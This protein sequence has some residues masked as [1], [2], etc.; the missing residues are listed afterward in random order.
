MK[1]IICIGIALLLILS[2]CA[3]P[4]STPLPT[5]SFTQGIYEFSFSVEQ[6]SG[7]V[8]DQWEFVY[9]YNDE[10]ITSG[11]QILFSLEIFTF[12]SIQVDVIEE[13][14][15]HNTYSATFPVAICAGGSGKTEIT[16]TDS[17]GTTATF[18]ISCQL[19]QIGKQELLILKPYT[20]FDI[21]V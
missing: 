19:T 3:A 9:T 6:L 20:H 15:P 5:E 13:G 16:V 1:K 10:T 14:A 7:E 21:C 4:S 8:T 17:H 11:H 2:G 18:Q 12:H